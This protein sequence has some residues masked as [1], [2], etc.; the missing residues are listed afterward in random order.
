MN[1]QGVEVSDLTI[2]FKVSRITVYNWLNRW[3]SDGLPGLYNRKGQGR[4]PILTD[5]DSVQVEERVWENCQQLKEVRTKL[6]ADLSRDFSD[7][8]LKR[9]LK[10]L[11][12]RGGGSVKVWKNLRI[13]RSMLTK[14]SAW[15]SYRSLKDKGI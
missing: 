8:T 13:R 11:V 2:I 10:S 12:R 9:F 7:K 14:R 1:S 15:L 3:D 6:K 5:A 4:K